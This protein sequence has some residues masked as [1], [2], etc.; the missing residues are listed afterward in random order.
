MA[1]FDWSQCAVCCAREG[2]HLG[3]KLLSRQGQPASDVHTLGVQQ[4]GVGLTRNIGLYPGQVLGQGVQSFPVERRFRELAALHQTA[5]AGSS[6][7]LKAQRCQQLVRS[8][9]WLGSV[10][11]RLP[12]SHSLNL[13]C[14]HQLLLHGSDG[15]LQLVEFISEAKLCLE[16]GGQD[17][18]CSSATLPSA[19]FMAALRQN[20]CS[21][22]SLCAGV[23][24]VS[25]AEGLS[26][27]WG[28][29]YL[30]PAEFHIGPA[31][32]GL[33]SGVC[34]LQVDCLLAQVLL[35]APNV[36]LQLGYLFYG[37]WQTLPFSLRQDSTQGSQRE[38]LGQVPFALASQQGGMGQGKT[39]IFLLP[40]EL[41]VKTLHLPKPLPEGKVC[42]DPLSFQLI[43]GLQAGGRS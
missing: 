22:R 38:L 31:G 1:G 34:K 27:H 20:A 8:V 41:T 33:Q 15:C 5:R 26:P 7:Q 6:H 42:A 29:W 24:E 11:Q 39:H 16:A 32:S 36:F 10:S 18:I 3:H 28:P 9:P 21:T 25:L 35:Q 23:Y 2:V 37:L 13:L 4:H 30:V 12:P 14:L 40:L 17:G 19:G 43:V